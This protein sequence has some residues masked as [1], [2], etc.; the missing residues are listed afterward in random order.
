[1]NIK[2]GNIT[3]KEDYSNV[4]DWGKCLMV[5][6]TKA[7]IFINFK[8]DWIVDSGCGHYLIGN[9]IKFTNLHHIKVLMQLSR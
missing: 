5:E 3:N 1:M 4:E 7:M 8:N 2:E 9:G 6:T